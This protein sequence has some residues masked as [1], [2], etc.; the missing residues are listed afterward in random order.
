[1]PCHILNLVEAPNSA[2]LS[3]GFTNP[4]AILYGAYDMRYE[5]HPLADQIAPGNVRVRIKSLGICGS[6]VHFYKKVYLGSRQAP[7]PEA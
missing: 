7:T 5:D 3:A 2:G 4:A 6:D 1:M